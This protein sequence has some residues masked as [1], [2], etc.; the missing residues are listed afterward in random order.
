MARRI[1]TPSMA[2]YTTLCD[3]QRLRS[4]IIALPIITAASA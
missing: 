3:P 2:R 1:A 4:S